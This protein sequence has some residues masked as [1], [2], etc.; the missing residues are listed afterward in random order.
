ME[1]IVDKDIEVLKEPIDKIYKVV[2]SNYLINNK[3]KHKYSLNELKLISH[4]VSHIKPEDSKLERKF[5]NIKD[6]G[7]DY[8]SKQSSKYLHKLCNDLMSKPF[9]IYNEELKQYITYNWFTSLGYGNGKISYTFID[10]LKPY[11]LKLKENFTEYYLSNILNLSSSYDIRFYEL[12][13]QFLNTG[14]RKVFFSNLRE[15]LYVPK[16]YTANDVKKLI[17][18]AQINLE[19]HTD[20]KFGYKLNKKSRSFDNI[21]FYIESNH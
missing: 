17:E 3:S 2:K 7:L 18:K 11:L 13:K 9:T 16:S 4:L 10:D 12:L 1:I 5:I 20:I 14:Y 8:S 19:K 21:E 6:L 15:L